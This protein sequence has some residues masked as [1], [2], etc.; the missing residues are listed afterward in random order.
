MISKRDVHHH[1]EV[2]LHVEHHIIYLIV[3]YIVFKV[4]MIILNLFLTF[5]LGRELQK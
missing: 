2:F 4:S 3:R 1:R 5:E